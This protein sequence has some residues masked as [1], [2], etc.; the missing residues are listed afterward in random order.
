MQTTARLISEKNVQVGGTRKLQY[1]LSVDD[2]VALTTFQLF[3]SGRYARSLRQARLWVFCFAIFPFA[4]V[5]VFLIKYYSW[6]VG[7]VTVCYVPLAT[8]H[9]LF[10]FD[11]RYE[12]I[13]RRMNEK[14]F[15]RLLNERYATDSRGLGEHTVEIEGD[16]IVS[17]SKLSEGRCLIAE[18]EIKEC[19]GYSF[20]FL[21]VNPFC[22][23]SEKQIV[24]GSLEAFLDEIK[25]RTTTPELGAPSDGLQ[26]A[27]AGKNPFSIA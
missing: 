26:L 17:C 25:S 24:E 23:L 6:F 19:G 11:K 2:L 10:F 5:G 13:Y 21:G 14:R 16:W 7:M 22:V 27:H 8:I 3:S 20:V 4:I 18:A 15:R 9:F 1:N 12:R